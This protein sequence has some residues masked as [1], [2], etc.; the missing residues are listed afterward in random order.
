VGYSIFRLPPAMAV[1]LE[2]GGEGGLVRASTGIC[3]RIPSD[4]GGKDH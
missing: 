1:V 2:I 3:I 4:Q